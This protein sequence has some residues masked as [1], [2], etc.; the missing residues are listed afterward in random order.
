MI[1]SKAATS[2]NDIGVNFDQLP[3][4]TSVKVNS[5]SKTGL[6]EFDLSGPIADSGNTQPCVLEV[7][8]SRNLHSDL[9][10][11]TVT[12]DLNPTFFQQPDTSARVQSSGSGN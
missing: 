11:Y 5:T 4:I 3:L 6:L 2:Q 12:N 1:Y 9:N 8:S 7:S 10:T